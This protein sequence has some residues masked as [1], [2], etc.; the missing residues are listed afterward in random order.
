[1]ASRMFIAVL[2]LA[3]AVPPGLRAEH[4]AEAVARE[5]AQSPETDPGVITLDFAE[6]EAAH[7]RLVIRRTAQGAAAVDEL[8]VYG[9]ASTNNLALASGGATAGASSVISGYTIH[10]IAHLNDGRYGN[11]HSWIAASGG[12]DWAGVRLA[13]P[14]RI[15]RVVFARDR[16][17]RVT[18]RQVLD[19]SVL[20]SVDGG[21]WQPVAT[22]K[23][24]AAPAASLTFPAGELRERS[25][26][27]VLEYAFL[28]EA[29]HLEPDGREDDLS[30]CSTTGRPYPAERP[31]GAGWPA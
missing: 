21:A 9:P 19:A 18:D 22:L 13:A 28:Q 4:V 30:P 29:R 8:E 6:R 3:A 11:D 24:S 5:L 1:M 26:A 16:T 17:G 10:A 20:V 15:N 14:A 25:W 7:V 12:E 23:R 31:T 2:L 27:G